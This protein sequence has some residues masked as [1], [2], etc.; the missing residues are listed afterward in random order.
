[1]G[2][3]RREKQGEIMD[4]DSL[5]ETGVLTEAIKRSD[6]P[7]RMAGVG[8]EGNKNKRSLSLLKA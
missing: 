4:R 2:E 3:K 7:R 1:M 6:A 5:T 8:R